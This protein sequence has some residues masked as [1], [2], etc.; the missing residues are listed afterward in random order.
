MLEAGY[1]GAGKHLRCQAL[2]LEPRDHSATM[3]TFRSSNS[4]T[5][6]KRHA[7]GAK[8]THSPPASPPTETRYIL[9]LESPPNTARGRARAACSG[10]SFMKPVMCIADA[11]PTGLLP[12]IGPARKARILVVDYCPD[13]LTILRLFLSEE[14]F[15]VS[16]AGGARRHCRRWR[17]GCRVSSLLITACPM[18]HCTR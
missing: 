18:M 10:T 6:S 17:T 9:P 8:R 1:S 16:T 3:R 12:V 15:E 11:E 4:T 13:A 14:G 2:Q 7:N 5:G